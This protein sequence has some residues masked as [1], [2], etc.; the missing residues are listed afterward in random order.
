MIKRMWGAGGGPC[1][2]RRA[3]RDA[4]KLIPGKSAGDIV[5]PYTC[6]GVEPPR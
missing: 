5:K 3:A 4:D 2:R 6:G 1:T